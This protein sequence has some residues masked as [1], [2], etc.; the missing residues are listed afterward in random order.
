MIQSKAG[1][2]GRQSTWRQFGFILLCLVACLGFLFWDGLR[3]GHTVFSNDGPLG[4]IS[5]Q[6]ASFSDGGW[7]GVWKDLNWLGGQEPGASPDVTCLLA[8]TCGPLLFS[9][10]YAPFALLFLGLS[11][12]LCF[13]QWKLSPLACL[14]GGLAAALNSDFFSTACWGVASQP[15]SFG[16]DFLALAALADETS[17]RRWLRVALA[18][19]AVGMGVMEAF[20][21]GAVFSIVVAAICC[22]QALAGEGTTPQKL[23]RL[24]GRLAVVVAFAAF[25]AISAVIGLVGTQIKGVAGMGQDAAS[26]AQRWDEATQWSLP[27]AEAL[28]L[29]VPGLFGFRM[30]TPE[31]GNYWGRCGRDPAWDRY[32]AS[33]KQGSRQI[34]GLLHPLWRRWPLRWG[35]GGADRAVERFPV[36]AQAEFGVLCGRAQVHL[37]LERRGLD[38]PAGGFRPFRALLPVI[39]CAAVRLDHAQP[40]QVLSRRRVDPGH[41]V[42]LRRARL[43]PKLPRSRPQAPRGLSAQLRSWW[44]KAAAFD[45]N[46]VRGSA[47]AL[48]AGLVGWLIYSASRERLVAYLQEVF[49]LEG[50]GPEDAAAMAQAVSLSASGRRAGLSCSWRWPLVWSSWCLSGYFSGRRAR[51]GAILLG[52]LLVADL[53][54]ANVPWVVTWNWVQK[55]ATN[56]V[57][58]FLREKPYE[59]RVAVLPFS[60]PPQ[61]ALFSHL[62]DIEWK[63]QLFQYYNIQSLDVVMMPRAPV[64]YVAFESALFFDGTTNTLHRLTRHWQLTNTRYLLGAAGFLDVLN[65]QIDPVQHRFRIAARFDLA[66]KPGIPEPDRPG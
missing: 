39:L 53:G 61:F 9:K 28:S 1:I 51:S 7:F 31:G 50:R 33:G 62:Y 3:P 14:L 37:V 56:P 15:L 32:F 43:E 49:G 38:L 11:A 63:Q 41:P 20:D 35:G 24:A 59:H 2:E 34:R 45:K 66:P 6:W 44:A 12:W 19:F 64:D 52:L 5:A 13:R 18:G 60:P 55:Y 65:Q 30:D 25:I 47:I 4:A 17:P 21:I 36:L 10:I 54:R 58:D 46:W 8:Y 57:I 42:R 29:V 23:T 26:K 48:A 16:L 22:F 27:K 40:V